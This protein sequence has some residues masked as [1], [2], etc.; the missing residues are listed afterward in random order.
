MTATPRAYRS[1]WYGSHRTGTPPH[2]AKQC[3]RGVAVIY[4]SDETIYM[5]IYPRCNDI[6]IPQI[7]RIIYP[8]CNEIYTYPR[9]SDTPST[10]RTRRTMKSFSRGVSESDNAGQ[11][12]RAVDTDDAEGMGGRGLLMQKEWGWGGGWVGEGGGGGHTPGAC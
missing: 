2:H 5:Y 11:G 3:V 4:T 9:Y 12:G 7:Q 8:R 6:Y 1:A 10:P